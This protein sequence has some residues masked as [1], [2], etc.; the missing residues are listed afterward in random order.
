[1]L[2]PNKNLAPAYQKVDLS[3]GYDVKPWVRVFSSIENLFD[4]HYQPV[5]GFPALPFSIRG[6]MKFTFGGEHGFW[7]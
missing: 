7:K 6:G 3:A 1:M 2:L 5:F 4:E